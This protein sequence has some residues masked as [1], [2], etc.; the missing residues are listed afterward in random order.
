VFND[1]KDP[2]AYKLV[3]ASGQT[4]YFA[5]R[6]DPRESVLTPNSAD[7]R[8]KVADAVTGL[9]YVTSLDDV[10]TQRGSGPQTREIWWVLLLIVIGIL[11]M[12][13]WY[14][15]KLAKKGEQP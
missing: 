7:D 8:K 6:T 4:H 13:V 9:Q 15:R 3:T 14:T 5:V 2:G 11:G 12:E 10:E 1:T